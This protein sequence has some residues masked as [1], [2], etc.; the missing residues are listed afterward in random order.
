MAQ[1]KKRAAA[2][3]PTS[4]SCHSSLS[5]INQTVDSYPCKKTGEESFYDTGGPST[6]SSREIKI[7]EDQDGEQG[8]SMDDIWKD[9]ALSMEENMLQ[10]V[11]DGHSEEGCNFSCPPMHSPSWEY[12]SDSL[13]MMDEEGGNIFLPIG[14]Q[15][16]PYHEQAKGEHF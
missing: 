15:S 7:V 12:S 5:S 9:I 3:S 11:Y 13:W 10:P 1:E 4:S 2:S 6:E 16:F 14:H 8:Y